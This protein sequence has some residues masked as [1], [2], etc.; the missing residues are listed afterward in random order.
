[1]RTAYGGG[2]KD[3]RGDGESSG[4]Y[5][6]VQIVL[7]HGARHSQASKLCEQGAVALLLT[8]LKPWMGGL[9]RKLHILQA[10]VHSSE[11]QAR[12]S[13]CRQFRL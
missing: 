9:G 5:R 8:P 1:M 11:F 2:G 13:V 7:E 10:F 4:G 3:G 12:H 6:N